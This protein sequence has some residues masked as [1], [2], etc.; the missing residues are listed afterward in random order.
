MTLKQAKTLKQGDYIHSVSQ[1]NAD[2]TPMRAKITS[3]KLWKTRP[4]E[5]RI[6]YKHGL[7]DYGFFD[8]TELHLINL[9]YK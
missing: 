8:E 6:N 2:K 9:G 3:I 5:I 7:Y 4:D 1:K